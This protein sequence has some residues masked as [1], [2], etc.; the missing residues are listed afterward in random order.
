M[1]FN[2]PFNQSLGERFRRFRA[3]TLQAATV[4]LLS[5][6]LGIGTA[7]AATNSESDEIPPLRPPKTE[8]LPSYWDEHRSGLI[9]AAAALLFVTFII[10]WMILRPRR[11]PVVSPEAQARKELDHLL[12]QP[13]TGALLSH[14]SQIIRRYVSSA[15]KLPVAEL[16]TA[17]FSQTISSNEAVGPGLAAEISEFLRACDRRKF[18]PASDAPP[19][20][21]VPRAIDFITQ[22]EQ[23]CAELRNAEQNATQLKHE[24]RKAAAS[25]T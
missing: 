2:R 18:A 15:F 8:I 9:L 19:I 20:N 5:I 14:V 10:V 12:G 23:R 4:F 7:M 21:A 16:T 11:Q 25:D 24:V 6:G 17:E 22:S 13:E 3:F 1:T